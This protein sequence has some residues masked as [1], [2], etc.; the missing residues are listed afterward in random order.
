MTSF[1]SLIEPDRIHGSL[2]TDAAIFSRE[3]KVI[4]RDGWAFVGHE[5]EIP[6]PGDYITRTIGSEPVLFLRNKDGEVRV[7]SNRC[8]HRGN[9]LCHEGR[10][11]LRGGI[12]C[13]Y[14]GWAFSFDGDLLAVP[15]E[16]GFT[17]AKENYSLRQPKMASHRGFVFAT[18]NPDPEDFY[19]YLGYG[20]DLIDKSVSMSPVGKIRL[21]SGWVKHL[22]KA[23]W[24][25][26]PENQTDGYHANHVHKSFLKVFSSQYDE[27][28]TNEEK[29]VGSVV[30]WGNGHASIEVSERYD[31]PLQ[32]LGSN[33]E[34]YPEYVKAMNEAYG[35]NEARKLMTEGPPHAYIFPNLFLGEANIV[36][37]EPVAPDLSV[38]HHSPMLLEGVPEGLN[39]RIIR[40]SEGALGPSGLLLADDSVISEQQQIALQGKS[41]WLEISR[42]VD[43][44]RLEDGKRIGHVSDET[45]NRGF[46]QHY[47]AKMNR[48]SV[49]A[50]VEP[51]LV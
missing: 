48:S 24:K 44:E 35:E 38:Q 29:R 51:E 33:E 47:L 28:K 5:S 40:Q 30:D 18:Y 11:K 22:F 36:I 19:D 39:A 50:P 14:H 16:G 2:Y 8:T 31:G 12:M 17:K 26:L 1:A 43:R 7:F 10:G 20:K 23:N 41:G 6:E 27:L 32:W 9:R 34:R 3:M 42:G 49:E 4:F 45:T 21:D 46:W 15:Y 37:I 13:T 25:M